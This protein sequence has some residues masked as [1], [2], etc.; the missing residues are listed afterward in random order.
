MSWVLIDDNFPTHPRT[1]RSGPVAAYLF[2][3]MLCY[4][5][6]HHTGG[7]IPKAAVRTLGVTTNPSKLVAALLESGLCIE[8]GDNYTIAGYAERYDD[9]KT[10]AEKNESRRRRQV[11]GR[12]GGLAKASNASS[13]ASCDDPSNALAH[14]NG[15]GRI[16]VGSSVVSEEKS[17]DFSKT[18]QWW[19]E[20][21]RLYPP[22]RVT[23]SRYVQGLF[24]EQFQEDAR[25]TADVWR[26]MLDGLESQLAGYEWRVKGMVPSLEKWLADGRWRQ[27]HEAAP[28]SALVTEKTARNLTAAA[29]FIKAGDK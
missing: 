21:C 24:L 4:C 9:E 29:A 3:C 28:V 2:V 7:A 13:N 8:D 12:K 26:D 1:V 16:G 27:R 14:R 17:K 10:V 23:P 18:D 25:P 6:K 22:Q 19:S 20:L 5:R 15:P 11:A